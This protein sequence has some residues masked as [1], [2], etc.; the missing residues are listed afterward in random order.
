M[1]GRYMA[2]SGL[3]WSISFTVGPYFAGLLLD[4][5]NPGLL[6]VF[7]GLIGIL[8]TLGFILLNKTQRSP[9]AIAEPAAAD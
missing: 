7:C 6:W 4:S 5:S 2:V 8:A 1:R 9:A 3:S